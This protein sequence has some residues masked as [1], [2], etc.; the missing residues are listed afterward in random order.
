M[1]NTF[2]SEQATFL[3]TCIRSVDFPIPGSPPTKTKEPLTIPPPNT[4]SNSSIPVVNLSSCFI[5]IE[6]ILIGFESPLFI[7]KTSF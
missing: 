3:D 4:L 6:F 2:L 5:S 1:Y 7:I